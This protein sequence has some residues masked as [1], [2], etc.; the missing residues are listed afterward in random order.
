MA[1]RVSDP[2]LRAPEVL[3]TRACRVSD[4]LLRAPEVLFT[5][6]YTLHVKDG[7]WL[8]A[9][10]RDYIMTAWLLLLHSTRLIDLVLIFIHCKPTHT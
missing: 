10:T 1:C 8:L 4:P 3:F 9:T 6:D 7:L 2:L 5:R